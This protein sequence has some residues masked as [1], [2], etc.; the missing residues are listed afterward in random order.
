[1]ILYQGFLFICIWSL[2]KNRKEIPFTTGTTAP[3]Y[4]R[5]LACQIT[6]NKY[7]N[8]KYLIPATYGQIAL[9]NGGPEH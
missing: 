9:I 3:Y 5:L 7:L 4:R 8:N 6:I 2:P 1:M